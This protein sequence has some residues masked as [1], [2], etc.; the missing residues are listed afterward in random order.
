MLA[1]IENYNILRMAL[2][3]LLDISGYRMDYLAEQLGLSKNYFYAKKSKNKFSNDEFEKIIAF[4]WRD[5]FQDILDEEIIKQKMTEGKNL[6]GEEF[7][8]KMGWI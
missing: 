5:E 6:T 7:K 3:R 8:R 2:P 1:V 4:I